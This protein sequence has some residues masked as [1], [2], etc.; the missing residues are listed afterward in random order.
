M[1][2]SS[3]EFYF[4]MH[5]NISLLHTNEVM[6]CRY[7]WLSTAEMLTPRG[8]EIG[9]LC[10]LLLS[11]LGLEV[12]RTTAGSSELT[13]LMCGWRLLLSLELSSCGN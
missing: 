6:N 7:P 8:C 12:T 5:V 9:D 3:V 13:L 1:T 2:A 10:H 4:N 11:L